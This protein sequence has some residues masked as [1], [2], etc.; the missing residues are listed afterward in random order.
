MQGLGIILSIQWFVKPILL[1]NH[2]IK[3]PTNGEKFV[4]FVIFFSKS[5]KK[6]NKPG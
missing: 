6:I 5:F 4:D 1:Q 3:K 2:A